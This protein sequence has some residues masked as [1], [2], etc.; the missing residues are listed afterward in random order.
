LY[1]IKIWRFRENSE[2]L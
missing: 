2:I 1:T